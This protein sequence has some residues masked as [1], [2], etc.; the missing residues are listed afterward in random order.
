MEW[1]PGAVNLGVKRPGP[2]DDHSPPSSAEVKEC[3]ELYLYFPNTPSWRGAELQK[4]TGTTLPLHLP[5]PLPL[6]V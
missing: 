3:L 2:E 5:L 6:G 1:V 4:S